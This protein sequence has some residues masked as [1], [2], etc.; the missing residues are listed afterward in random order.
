MHDPATVSHQQYRTGNGPVIDLLLHQ[1][2]DRFLRPGH[3]IHLRG[4]FYR[5]V[6]ASDVRKPHDGSLFINTD[7]NWEWLADEAAKAA[8]VA[9]PACSRARP[10]RN[11]VARPSAAA[12]RSR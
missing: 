8:R 4:L 2:I 5:I 10:L 6:S 3:T 9:A 11:A 1:Q 7:E 12:R